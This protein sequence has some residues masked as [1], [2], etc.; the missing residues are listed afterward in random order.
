MKQEQLDTNDCFILD[1]ENA[2]VYVWVGKKCNNQEKTKAMSEAQNFVSTKKYPSWVKVQ[3]IVENAEPS[4]FRQY[5]Q[6][7]KGYGDLHSRLI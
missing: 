3:R 7:W 4:V 6:T 2:D 5:F 1:T